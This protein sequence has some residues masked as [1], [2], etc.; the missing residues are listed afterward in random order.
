MTDH[1]AI[2]Q[3]MA[4]GVGGALL[5]LLGVDAG[6]LTAALIGCA[7]GAAA[8]P[9]VGPWR[10][11]AL[12]V[13]AVAASAISASVLGPLAHGWLPGVSVA[14]LCKASALLVGILLHPLIQAGSAAVPRI[15]G[16]VVSRID[17][18]ATP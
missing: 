6:T 7:F 11:R 4:A 17:R 13:A 15:V 2:V 9:P 16:A 12:F 10:A 1:A 14:A 18:S 5:A 3:G 8:A